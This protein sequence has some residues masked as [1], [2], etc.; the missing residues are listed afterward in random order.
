MDF[1][2][3]RNIFAASV[4][5]E[6]IMSRIAYIVWPINGDTVA[7]RRLLSLLR[8]R[9]RQDLR[10]KRNIGHFVTLPN[11]DVHNSAPTKRNPVETED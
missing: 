2:P 7:S 1:N 6:K 3:S 4:M 10:E 5:A 11:A 9:R 8:G